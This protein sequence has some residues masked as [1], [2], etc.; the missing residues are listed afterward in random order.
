MK[1]VLIDKK[2]RIISD[3]EN[4]AKFMNVDLICTFASNEGNGYDD[5]MYPEMLCDFITEDGED[6]PF[7][8]Y[9]YEFKVI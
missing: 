8:L 3:N 2:V 5:C 1:T 4:Y 6:F 9:E 7:A